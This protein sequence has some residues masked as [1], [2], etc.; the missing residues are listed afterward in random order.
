MAG[1]DDF[2]FEI[3]AD[4]DAEADRTARAVARVAGPLLDDRRKLLALLTELPTALQKGA[5]ALPANVRQILRD[6]AHDRRARATELNAAKRELQALKVT[7]DALCRDGEVDSVE[8][9]VAH[10]GPD[11][12]I[13]RVTTV[14]R[15]PT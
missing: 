9:H 7:V 3:E 12:K 6:D 5:E 8:D 1:H 2:R 13:A 4:S 15:K 10:R 14:H 11:G